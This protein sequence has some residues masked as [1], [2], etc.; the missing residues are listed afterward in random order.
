MD[1]APSVRSTAL[2]TPHLAHAPEWASVIERAYGHRPLYLTAVDGDGTS[3]LLPAFVVRRPIAGTI[4]TSMPFLD[5]GGPCTASSTLAVGLVERLLSEAR[6]V[7]AATVEIRSSVRLAIEWTPLEHKVNM[8][9]PLPADPATL[10]SGFDK[11]VRNQIRKAEKTGLAV[12]PAGAEDLEA[13]YGVFAARMHELGSPV[14]ALPFFRTIFEA[15]GDR[16]HLMLVQKG[17]EVVG[18]LIALAARETLVVPW[19]SCATEFRALCPN[20]LLYWETLR[21]GCTLGFRQFDFGRS[22]RGSGTY[23]FKRQWGASEQQ[24]YWYTIP[25][26]PNQ[27]VTP[28]ADHES[29]VTKLAALWRHLPLRL[30]RQ[31]GPRVRKYL[32]Q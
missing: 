2:I 26:R 4:V 11:S 25:L 19:A 32:V 8:T 18:G 10:W 30:T 28:T 22:T 9:L 12:R 3:G 27:R 1:A 24:L 6:R 17:D 13:F 5:G 29:P 21:L 16:A 7:G 23:D 20:M 31:L 15:F 14:H